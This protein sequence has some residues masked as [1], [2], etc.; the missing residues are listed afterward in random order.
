ML[1]FNFK[2]KEGLFGTLLLILLFPSANLII[3]NLSFQLGFINAISPLFFLIFLIVPY[4]KS[5]SVLIGSFIGSIIYSIIIG[6]PISIMIIASII[7][8]ITL[9][10]Y[11]RLF[12]EEPEGVYQVLLNVLISLLTMSFSAWLLSLMNSVV[13]YNSFLQSFN[14]YFFFGTL[15]GV[16]I[17]NFITVRFGVKLNENT[18]WLR[19]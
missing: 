4:L 2:I 6:S 8:T 14:A 5:N 15:I 17:V 11:N 13:S 19:K 9:W 1:K 3:I 18:V 16:V 12:Y 7:F 10:I